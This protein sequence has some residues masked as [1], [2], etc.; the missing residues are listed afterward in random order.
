MTKTSFSYT[1]IKQNSFESFVGGLILEAVFH[2][3]DT[4]QY[5]TL[6]QRSTFHAL[7]SDLHHWSTA[8]GSGNWV[9]ALCVDYSKAF[10][11]LDHNVLLNK[12]TAIGIPS[13][14]HT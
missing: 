13:S 7:V 14:T 9:C 11:Q 3:F 5:G 8:L 4:N 1:N 10:D 12:M 6:K 2:Q